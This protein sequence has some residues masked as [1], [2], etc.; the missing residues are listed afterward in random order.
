MQKNYLRILLLNLTLSFFTLS[1]FSQTIYE[2]YQDGIVVFQLKK[3]R[4]YF[5]KDILTFKK[6]LV[7][8]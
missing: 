1:V 5:I 6:K 4:Q 3:K 7:N 2:S 8:Y